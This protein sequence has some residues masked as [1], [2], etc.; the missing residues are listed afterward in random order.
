MTHAGHQ[1]DAVQ[2]DLLILGSGAAAFGAATRARELGKMAVMVEE[3]TLGGTCVNRGCLPSKNLI[4]AAKLVYDAAHPRFSGLT[5]ASLQPDFPALVAQKDALIQQYR[6]QHY[7]SILND[8]DESSEPP[9]TRVIYGRATLVDPHTAAVTAPD[10]SLRRISGDQV[11]IATG[12]APAIPDSPGLAETP[13]LTSDLLTSHEARELGELPSSLV[14]LGGGYIALELGQLFARLGSDVTI[15]EPARR[16]LPRYE[17]E[18]AHRLTEIL[19]EEG[20]RIVPGARIERITGDT[21]HVSVTARVRGQSLAFTAATLL[22]ATGRRPNTSDLGLE[23]VGIRLDP[24]TGAVAVDAKLRTSVPHIW[25]AGDAI[26]HETDSQMA[27]PVAAHD[28]GLA[29]SN[30][31]AGAG[32]TVNHAIIPRAIFTDPPVGVVGLTDAEATAAGI[33]CECSAIPLSVVPR[34]GAIRDTRGV[35]KLVLERETRRVVGVS[36]LG[37]EAAEVVQVASLGMRYGMTAD[38]LIDQ[39]FIY[40]TMAE[41]LRIAAISFTRDVRTLSCCAS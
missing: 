15:L 36:M 4:A 25:A 5:P 14:I 37:A 7:A 33:A 22:V 32:R 21:R 27:T 38:D 20:L 10:G 28:G 26:G 8:G 31:L 11:L 39:L 2:A 18:I 35:V 6:D 13:Y 40:P 9:P 3:R 12:S 17:P 19:R 24:Q 23:Q 41:A 1:H 30:A 29:A 34:A 16:I